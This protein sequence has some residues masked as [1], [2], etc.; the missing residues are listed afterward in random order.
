MKSKN[1]KIQILKKGILLILT[2]AILLPSSI[3]A[4]QSLTLQE[5]TALEKLMYGEVGSVVRKI[6]E[7]FKSNTTL[8]IVNEI[9]LRAL[10]EYVNSGSSCLGKKIELLND[11][12]LDTDVDWT[13]IGNSYSEFS[14]TFNGNGYT[15]TNL[16]YKC[17]ENYETE[18]GYSNVGLFGVISKNGK[19]EKVN[20]S[21]SNIVSNGLS[22]DNIFNVG[23]IA[24]TNYGTVLDCSANIMPLGITQV[25]EGT[26]ENNFIGL[27]VGENNGTIETTTVEEA[28]K[29]LTL[30]NGTMNITPEMYLSIAGGEYTKLT[31]S[32]N[33]IYLRESDKI[34]LEITLDKY[35]YTGLE[36]G[37]TIKLADEYDEQGELV[38]KALEE[39]YPKLSSGS[40][41][42][43][44]VSA[45]VEEVENG[46]GTKIATTKLVYEFLV[47][48]LENTELS[49]SSIILNFRKNMN[50]EA[51]YIYY[52]DDSEN[53]NTED[54]LKGT[55]GSVNFNLAKLEIDTKAP[56]IKTEAYV[57]EVTDSRRYVAGKEI[58]IKATSTEKIQA[59]IAPEIEVDFSKSGVGK[60]NY[61]ENSNKGNAKHIDAIINSDGTTTWIYSYIIQ[62]GDEGILNIEYLSGS[63]TDL[64]GN[65]ISITEDSNVE[66]LDI[67]ADT[68]VP[69]VQIIAKDIENSLT[70]VN[71]ITYEFKWSEKVSGFTTE[72]IT[73]NNGTKG[74]LSSVIENEDGT[75]AYTMD[76]TASVET[77]NVGDLQVIVEQ[78][79]CTDLAGFGN[80]R[81]ESSIRVDKKA[82]ILLS[83]E[84]YATSDIALNQEIDIVK[85]YYKTNET[86][87]IIATF[88]ENLVATEIPTLSLQFSESG[89]A[90]GTVEGTLDGN[91]IT[92]VYKVTYGDK[93][94]LT[95]KGFTGVV[96]DRIGNETKVTKRVLD[97][98]TII[99]D[100]VA[101]SLKEL[102]VTT[103]EGK[104][105][106]GNTVKIEAIYD[107]DVYILKDN[108]IKNITSELA[109]ILKVKFG[110][111]EEKMASVIG[112]GTKEDGSVDKTKI[113]YT[114]E[115][116][117]GEN[118]VLVITSYQ[119]KEEVK[120]CDIAGNVATLNKNQTG[121]EITADTARPEVT[122]I[123]ASVMNPEISGTGIYHKAGN[124]IKITLTF[125]EK[126]SSAVLMP[127]IQIGF[128]E[129]EDEEPAIYNTYAYESDW[130][131]NS[132]T[133]EYSYD[134]K[135]GDNGYLWVKVPE[136]QFRDEAGNKNVSEEGAKVSNVFAD[137]ILPTI[138]LL[139]DTE[140]NQANQTITV[141]ATFSENIYDLNSDTRV[142]LS[143]CNAPKLIYSFGVGENKEVSASSIN[144]A[145]ITYVIN[146]DAVNDNGTLHYELAKG[147]LCDRAGN[148]YYQ[149]TTDTTAPI[150]ERVYISSNSEYGTYC[151]VGTE[152]YVT[153]AFN[154]EI[155]NQNMKLKIGIG[156]GQE[157]EISGLI[158]KDNNKQIIFTYKVLNGDNGE[159]KI[160][161]I[162][163][164]TSSDE[165][166][167]DKTYGYV[168]D[169]YGNQANIFNLNDYTVNGKAIADTIAPTLEITSDVEKT[170]K[171]IITYTFT[172]S[173]TVTGFT[174][175]DIDVTNGLKGELKTVVNTN[176]KVYELKVDILEEGRQIIKVN[177]GVC[178][179]LAGNENDQR[180][181]YNK[182]YI[183]Y[184][185]PVI[186]AKVN[187]GNYVIDTDNVK[188]T[189]AETIV[190]NEELSKFEY[191]WTTS[192]T[193]P[194]SG[195]K[196]EDINNIFV[197]SDINLTEE[198]SAEGTYYLYIRAIDVAGN[199][200]EVKTKGFV[201]S[202]ED[203][204]LTADKTE[205][206][207]D[208]VTVTVQYGEGLD[209]NRKAGIS[210][211]TQ[212]ADSSKVIVTE[213][214][215][216][217]AE[218]SDKA[219][220]RVYKKLEI[221]NIDKEAPEA[222]IEYV[223]NEDKTVTAKISFNED[224][225]ITN[226]SGSNEYVFT[227][228]GEFTFE[229]KDTAGNVG[230]AKAVVTSIE[231]VEEDKTAPVITFKY[232]LTTTTV[233]NSIGATIS[234]DEDAIISYSWDNSNWIASKDYIRN[235]NAIKVPTEAGT[236]ILYAKATDKSMNQ[237][238]V[239][240]LEFTILKAEEEIKEAEVIFEDLATVQVDGTKY[241]KIS[242]NIAV[243]NLTDKMDKAALCG[244]TPEF[245]NLTEDKQL[246]TGSEIVIDGDTKYVIIV[247]GDVNCDGKVT[248][249]GDIVMTN[250]YRI[251]IN[252]NL[253]TIQLLAADINNSGN[254]EFIPD[255][256]AMNNYRLGKI[257]SL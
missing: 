86:I 93:G 250:N 177:S 144:G 233:G 90:K 91:K 96:T 180:F 104:Y 199:Q 62:T 80:A 49:S 143:P 7:H 17:L 10:A 154:E 211:K 67:Y 136:N 110:T 197:N 170:N 45:T 32:I 88:D 251:G 89:N 148:E 146:K 257:N 125:S 210:G 44:P 202:E 243:D 152:I 41:I 112:Y 119:N 19:V 215:T 14:G 181:T 2:L 28:N 254:I 8:Y 142:T 200:T 66:I 198:F 72:D 140:I 116:E 79:V 194:E 127:E 167:E 75:Y 30:N 26:E 173:E 102:N 82:P 222:T 191:I 123:T 164:N 87:T 24:G 225:T 193:L 158:D 178:I 124:K 60:Y 196:Q 106:A 188:S 171:D 56:S 48:E 201:I 37:N 149:E 238:E 242:S 206:T 31:D 218:A 240:K 208:D 195:W 239:K 40:V 209:E 94:T 47:S 246:K 51:L 186:R 229:F 252:K 76:V 220:N 221:N 234:T 113:I 213:N 141:K 165:T 16:T 59:T 121:N 18:N 83:L 34:K 71:T 179:D 212:S 172:W 187:G 244:K 21:N 22:T 137:T 134:I 232:T 43:N 108:E 63:L 168:K 54:E 249:L 27:L 247:N 163:G 20:V 103:S 241:V 99:T 224:A 217:Y 139:K 35:L 223:T 52:S 166:L 85:E 84:G 69:T 73:V 4:T 61:Q 95:V 216:V 138:T 236:Y 226:N 118:G 131:V 176:G 175:S 174:T 245:T 190:I 97:G 192:E 248:F 132:K 155:S 74:E 184:T 33:T 81:T 228:N 230:T 156:E 5:S 150:L 157:K 38:E 77:G 107:E 160:L 147:N 126:V 231:I 29:E 207:N 133:I 183:D 162:I 70:N 130:N 25:E 256:V 36:D 253:N 135:D 3:Y 53:F 161:D 185:K 109:P 57:E 129:S 92:Y 117:D 122:N 120:V 237:S 227:E 145:T 6:E 39:T 100:T 101:P 159:F 153:A 11:I 151:K 114:C 55:S 78:D 203:I 105:N 111:A 64:S 58:I 255:I 182:V 9:Q 189:L 46:D 23:N 235:Q 42:F 169:L 15:I 68:T 115:I 214:G 1:Q 128:S 205:I 219:G 50:D 13:P 98:D 65:E 12:E 204:V